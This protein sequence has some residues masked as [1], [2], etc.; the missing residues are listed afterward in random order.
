MPENANMPLHKNDDTETAQTVDQFH[1]FVYSRRFL[2]KIIIMKRRLI[3]F[4]TKFKHL[5]NPTVWIS[6]LKEN[7]LDAI[8]AL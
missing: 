7:T 5:K 2:R 3:S 8:F 4:L 1:Y 6:M